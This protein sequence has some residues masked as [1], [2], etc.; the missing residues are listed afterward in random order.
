MKQLCKQLWIEGFLIV[1][2]ILPVAVMADGSVG[3]DSNRAPGVFSNFDDSSRLKQ[4]QLFA[5][6]AKMELANYMEGQGPA[7]GGPNL[8]AQPRGGG[9]VDAAGNP[10]DV[11]HP[12][13]SVGS[14]N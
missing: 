5:Q 8:Q 1:A 10:V 2:G 7:N 14:V 3:G 9:L 13:P 4:A 11:V 12:D 6:F